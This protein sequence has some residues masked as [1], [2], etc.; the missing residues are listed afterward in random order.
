MVFIKRHAGNIERDK[1][2]RL[3][4]GHSI[5]N[6]DVGPSLKRRTRHK[7]FAIDREHAVDRIIRGTRICDL[8]GIDRKYVPR[9]HRRRG[10]QSASPRLR[11]V[12][13]RPRRLPGLRRPRRPPRWHRPG[14]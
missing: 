3:L 12:P 8:R 1:R 4:V 13:L 11:R 10:R 5:V 7:L 2:R 6:R 9:L 14:A